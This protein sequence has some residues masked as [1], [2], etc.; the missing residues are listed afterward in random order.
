MPLSGTFDTIQLCDL[1]QWI[2]VGNMTGTL[3]LSLDLEDTYLVI[4]HG[5]LVALASDDPLRLDLGQVLLKQGYINDTQLSQAL[6]KS[7]S[8]RLANVLVEDGILE[9]SVVTRIQQQHVFETVLDLF[10]HEEGSFFFSPG[11]PTHPLAP[12]PEISKSN[13]LTK[14]IPINELVFEGM[15]RLDEWNNMRK[16]FPSSYVIVHALDGKS[17]NQ[18]WLKLKEFNEFTA[19]GELCLRMGNSRYTV[20]KDLYDAYKQGLIGVDLTASDEARQSTMGSTD[21]LIE[22]ARLLLLEKQFDEARA[23]LSTAAN[24]DPSNQDTRDLLKRTRESYLEYLYQQVPPHKIP[25]LDISNEQLAAI[26]FSPREHYLVSRLDGRWDVASL[27]V[28][29][30]LGELETLK[31]LNKLL[32]AGIAKF[33]P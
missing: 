11:K 18:V 22:N 12:P 26:K 33:L 29:T 17:T 1:L 4:Q 8:K 30:P 2:H 24:L 7:K 10:F 13:F 31:I 19:I 6:K 9:K 21:T 3:T 15:Q 16:V 23:V 27:V 20:Y 28:L 5:T 25:I 14:P 32:H